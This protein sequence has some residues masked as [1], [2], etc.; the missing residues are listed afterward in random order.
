M[1]AKI[2][3]MSFLLPVALIAQT[4][5]I[6]SLMNA[7]YQRGQF[8][9]AILVASHGKVLY[10]KAFGM[11]DREKKR[12][13]TT[14]T[15][16]YIGS[17]S[18]QFTAMGIMILHDRGKLQYSQSI[19]DFYPELPSCMQ[20]VTI[21]NLLYHTSGLA[22]FSEDEDLT[23]DSV[24]KKLLAQSALNFRPG[25]KFQ[26]CN[27]GYSLLGM[28]IEKISG[29]SLHDFM[30]ENIFA[31][32]GMSGT[33]VNVINHPDKTR[34]V[35]YSLYGTVNN[36]DSWMGGN[37]SILSTVND[38]Y[39]W[40]R[41]LE[42]NKLVSP[43]TLEEA[44][45]PSSVITGNPALVLKDDMFGEKSYGFGWWLA[46]REGA[47]D[48]WHDGAFSGHISYNERISASGTVVTALSNLRQPYIYDIR[49][50]IVNILEGK[51]YQLP[52]MD[53]TVWL[54]QHIK[55]LGID[56]AVEAYHRL[57]QSKD[58]DYHFSEMSQNSYA[59]I[60]LRGGRVGEAVKVF[61]LNTKLN[62]K[63]FNAWDS[64]ADGYEKAGEKAAA[65]EARKKA[66]EIDPSNEYE[67]NMLKALEG[68]K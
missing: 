8:T 21:R 2:I 63:S 20:P 4:R 59:Y 9:G 18:K 35:G 30:Q 22:L 39:K 45:T 27:A 41:A 11:A 16:E 57:Y 62:P 29:Q 13:F 15:R 42:G 66:L 32:L 60:L 50:A 10:D 65:I 53:G 51:P 56:S 46:T 25:E 28:I 67:K 61:Q 43:Q 34:A 36:E 47:Q 12:A 26:Y 38:L 55:T 14:D 49:Q 40:D 3:I 64:L 44:F 68:G 52:K 48:M 33:L 6:D 37:S 1:K 58:P 54:D 31:P 7:V 24:F 5:Q 17:I 23:E 19:R